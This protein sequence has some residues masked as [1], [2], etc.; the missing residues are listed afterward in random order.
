MNTITLTR[1]QIGQFGSFLAGLGLL[2]GAIGFVWQGGITSYII[3]AFALAIIG[4]AIWV[5][6][7]PKDFQD[8]V[9]GK[10]VRYGTVSVFSTLLLIGIVALFYI[11]IQREVIVTDMTIDGRFSLAPES[12]EITEAAKRSPLPIQ[13]TGFYYPEQLVL[14]EV[15]DQYYQL[16]ED[17]TDGQITRRYI[18]PI[19][20]P[21]ISESFLPFIN[22]GVNVFVSYLNE[23]DEIIGSA[24]MPVNNSGIQEAD[25]TQAIAKLLVAGQFKV[26]FETSTDTPDPLSI[27][28]DGLSILNNTLRGNGLITEPLSL[29]TLAAQNRTI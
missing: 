4:L 13:I 29:E 10:R 1:G 12:I 22:Q 16:Y 11:I 3:A 23:D 28:Q 27:E 18:N 25:M 7:T 17:A 8:F 6:M 5:W 20:E 14:R 15:D 21:A 2:T 26:Y 9:T 24:V 19:E